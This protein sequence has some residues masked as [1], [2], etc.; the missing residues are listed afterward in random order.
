M[1]QKDEKEDTVQDIEYDLDEAPPVGRFR[2]WH[3][4]FFS[5][6]YP[7]GP[8]VHA[9]GAYR[10]CCVGEEVAPTTGETHWH[11]YIEY[12][13]Q[14]SFKFMCDAYPNAWTRPAKGNAAQNIKYCSKER[15]V[16]EDGKP[17]KQG[18]RNDLVRLFDAAADEGLSMN[19]LALQN[20][21]G[22]LRYHTGIEKIRKMFST[23]RS[24][25]TICIVLYGASGTGKSHR[26]IID[27]ECTPIEYNGKFFE[28]YHGEERVLIDEFRHVDMSKEFFKKLI[29]RWE[30][31]VEIKGGY[32]NWR[33][34]LVVLTTNDKSPE[35]TWWNGGDDAIHRRV[36][37]V[38]VTSKDQVIDLD[39]IIQSPPKTVPVRSSNCDESNISLFD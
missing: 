8:N 35:T 21:A 39:Q 33:P 28:G 19:E 4:V 17:K 5:S 20:K 36:R 27:W 31:K 16:F 11:L 29:D 2:N 15:L 12:D 14:K 3:G 13:T 25:M 7:E 32:V 38:H 1:A 10:Y 24:E 9:A 26:A 37:W 30:L 22:F 18:K 6:H 23:P 34:K